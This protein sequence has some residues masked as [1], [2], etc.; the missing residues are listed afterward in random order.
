MS[1]ARYVTPEMIAKHVK[2]HRKT[3]LVALGKRNVE[4]EKPGK[5][6]T[7][8]KLSTANAFIAKEWPE[9]FQEAGPLA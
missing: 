6:R 2:R 1:I 9:A 7:I 8:L 5:T 4:V 3:V